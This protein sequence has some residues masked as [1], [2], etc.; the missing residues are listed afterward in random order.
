MGKY[1]F[2]FK[3]KS[4]F[5]LFLFI[6]STNFP[7]VYGNSII[8]KTLKQLHNS[9]LDIGL[10]KISKNDKDIMNIIIEDTYAIKKM[11]KIILGKYWSEASDI[12]KNEFSKKFV[13]FISSNYLKRFANV[14]KLE[15]KYE[16]TE[17]IGEKYIM[18]FTQFKFTINDSLKIN[19][20]L[21]RDEKNWKI[22]DVLLDGSIS[23][24][25]TKKS[26]FNKILEKGGINSL[27][28]ILSDQSK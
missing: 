28:K 6:S 23:E 17:E 3:L 8:P 12:E 11:S 16:K 21:I 24:I 2:N 20:L 14:N 13:E 19:Y 9:L 22:F 4:I 27:I 10:N 18:V 25:A 1:L 15:I 5:V 26:E 7:Y